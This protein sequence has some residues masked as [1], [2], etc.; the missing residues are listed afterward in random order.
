MPY[1]RHFSVWNLEVLSETPFGVSFRTSFHTNFQSFPNTI[2][3]TAF[4]YNIQHVKYTEIKSKV[5]T[6]CFR[7]AMI[8]FERERKC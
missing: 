8:P 1:F 7:Y 4:K 5:L 2:Q 6:A 3:E